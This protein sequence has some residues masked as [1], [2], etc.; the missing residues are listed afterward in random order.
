MQF[1][2]TTLNEEFSYEQPSGLGKTTD[3]TG[4]WAL[5]Q[6][7]QAQSTC[8]QITMEW[9]SSHMYKINPRFATMCSGWVSGKRVFY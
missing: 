3:V 6:Q 9:F 1:L 5:Q 4:Q 8:L 2:N 7:M